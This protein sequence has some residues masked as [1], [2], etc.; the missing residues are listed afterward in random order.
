MALCISRRS[1]AVYP[2]EEEFNLQFV[3]R[4]DIDKAKRTIDIGRD[5]AIHLHKIG[6][7]QILRSDPSEIALKDVLLEQWEFEYIHSMFD[8]KK[9]FAMNL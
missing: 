4:M 9:Y 1:I 3:S 5:K 2:E 7:T 6:Q 8:E